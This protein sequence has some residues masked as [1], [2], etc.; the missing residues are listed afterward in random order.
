MN[1]LQRSTL[2]L[3]LSLCACQS[4][5]RA[6]V[7]EADP[8]HRAHLLAAVASLEGRWRVTGAH[9]EEAQFVEFRVSSNGS[10]VRELMFPGTPQE[11]TNMYTLDGNELAMTHYCAGGNQPHMRATN[12]TG[13]RLA[14]AFDSVS[15]LEAD[16]EVYMG[17]MTLVLVD[18][19]HVEQHWSA[20]KAGRAR[21]RDGL[22]AGARA[23]T[24]HS[25]PSPSS[26]CSSARRWVRSAARPA[27]ASRYQLTGRRPSIFLRTRT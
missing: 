26:S 15:D 7:V 18:A 5:A 4:A 6:P 9:G 14:F 8:Q 20:Y 19:D 24:G 23:L 1:P 11:M 25:R 21:P 16:D 2:C 12:L 10:A 13:N 27:G 3:A 17:S 22:R